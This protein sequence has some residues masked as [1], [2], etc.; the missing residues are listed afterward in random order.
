MHMRSKI[1]K[2]Q[3]NNNTNKKM[4]I[5]KQSKG[6]ESRQMIAK[7]QGDCLH[8]C[9]VFQITKVYNNMLSAYHCII[10]SVYQKFVE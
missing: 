10:V 4:E 2:M 8:N 3:N 1:K 6:T 7:K 9:D 5:E